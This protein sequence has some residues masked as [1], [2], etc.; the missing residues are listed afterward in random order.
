[1]NSKKTIFKHIIIELLKIKDKSKALNAGRRKK[2]CIGWTRICTAMGGCL[3][4][5]YG[6]RGQWDSVVTNSTESTV[7][8]VSCKHAQEKG[9]VTRDRWRGEGEKRKETTGIQVHYVHVPIPHRDVNV[10]CHTHVLIKWSEKNLK[11]LKEFLALNSK[12]R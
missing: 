7:N 12:S 1:M 9:R 4:W 11:V 3:T 6:L 10:M 2:L 5:I 8:I